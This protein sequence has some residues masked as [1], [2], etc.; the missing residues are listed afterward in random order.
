MD[1]KNQCFSIAPL[2]VYRAAGRTHPIVIES[3]RADLVVHT[4]YLNSI[5]Q[6]LPPRPILSDLTSPI[7]CFL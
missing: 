2:A 1:R 6:P 4:A 3:R 7:F 5:H